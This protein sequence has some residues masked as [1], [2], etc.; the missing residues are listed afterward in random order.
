MNLPL[1]VSLPYRL[2]ALFVLAVFYGIYLIKQWRQKRRGIQTMQIGRG[3]EA[4]TH[5]VETLMG[6]ATVG[7]IPAQLLSIANGR[8]HLPAHARVTGVGDRR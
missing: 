5:T 8:R 6:I 3:K 7:I 2:L 1:E 4:Q